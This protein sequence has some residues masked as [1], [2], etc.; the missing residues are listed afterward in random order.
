MKKLNN[1]GFTLV[2]LLAVIAILLI[3]MTVALP[4]ISSAIERTKN[5][6]SDSMGKIIIAAGNLYISDHK[7][8]FSTNGNYCI[9]VSTLIGEDYLDSEDVDNNFADKCLIYQKTDTK[10]ELNDKEAKE[11][12]CNR[13]YT[14]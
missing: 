6:Q 2:E 10:I 9:K 4:N 12:S 11:C 1:K 8:N 13:E 5:K 3:I 14:Y 7:N